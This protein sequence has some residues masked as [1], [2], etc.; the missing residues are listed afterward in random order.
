[1]AK[2]SSTVRCRLGTLKHSGDLAW[3]NPK[4]V[5]WEALVRLQTGMATVQRFEKLLVISPLVPGYHYVITYPNTL[6]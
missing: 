5:G 4:A 6:F 3:R 1:M 2:R